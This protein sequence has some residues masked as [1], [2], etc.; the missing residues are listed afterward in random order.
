[1]KRA[2][3]SGRPCSLPARLVRDHGAQNRVG[4]QPDNPR[5]PDDKRWRPGQ[6]EQ[7]RQ[8]PILGQLCR[9]PRAVEIRAEGSFGALVLKPGKLGTAAVWASQI[10]RGGVEDLM[11]ELNGEVSPGA[12][13]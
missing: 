13:A 12:A 2:L 7:A 9:N 8:S 3:Q 6:L 1:M 5:P 4:L 11:D 10:P